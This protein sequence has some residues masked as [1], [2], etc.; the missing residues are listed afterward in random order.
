MYR[1]GLTLKTKIAV[2]KYD[3]HE[4]LSKNLLPARSKL[5]LLS[6]LDTVSYGSIWKGQ[7]SP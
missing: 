1:H 5:A 3:N 7:C 2:F 6:D 4:N